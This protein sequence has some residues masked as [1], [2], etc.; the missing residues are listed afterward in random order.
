MTITVQ[1]S[2]FRNN[3]AS[4][5]NRAIANKGVIRVMRGNKEIAEVRPKLHQEEITADWDNFYDDLKKI[6]A[7]QPKTKKKTNYSMR[8]DEILYGKR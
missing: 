3:M 8:V 5:I 4:F 7:M 1:I 2:E 6:W